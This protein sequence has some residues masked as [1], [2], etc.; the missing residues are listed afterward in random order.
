M[1]AITQTGLVKVKIGDVEKDI[2]CYY[3]W[4]RIVEAHGKTDDSGEPIYRFHGRVSELLDEL[5]FP[6]CTHF[7][8]SEFVSSMEKL[9]ASLGKAPAGE[10]TQNSPAPSDPGPSH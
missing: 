8:A 1:I 9:V 7:V 10:P 5:G 4:N 2:D 3:A 6:G